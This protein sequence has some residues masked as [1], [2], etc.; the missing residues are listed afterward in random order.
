MPC[1][2]EAL[3][4][5][6]AWRRYRGQ[7]VLFIGID[8]LDTDKPV[9]AFLEQFGITYPND[10]DVGTK[11]ARQYRITGVPETFFVARDGRLGEM[12]I[13]PL[14]EDRLINT[15]ERLLQE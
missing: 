11:I 2:D 12:V 10:P 3:I 5:E 7:G 9:Q 14:T 6:R 1:R 4:L 8:Y 15:I 13:G